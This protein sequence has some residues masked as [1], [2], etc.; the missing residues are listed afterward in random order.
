M[1]ETQ[2]LKQIREGVTGKA[3]LLFDPVVA[4]LVDGTHYTIDELAD[5]SPD[6]F[7]MRDSYLYKPTTEEFRRITNFNF[8]TNNQVT[9]ARAFTANATI[10]PAQIYFLLDVP[11]LNRCINEALPSL[12]AIERTEIAL[13]ANDNEYALPAGVHTKTQVLNVLYRD[14]TGVTDFQESSAPAWKLIE[15]GN[16]VTLHIITNEKVPVTTNTVAVIVWRKYYSTLAN[17]AATT[18]CPRELII[19]KVEMEVYKKLFKRHG[20]QAKAVFGQDLAIAE[21]DYM[22]ARET[23]IAPAEAREYHLDE[24]VEL[25][26]V[27]PTS[28]SW[29]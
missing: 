23:I 16:A 11:E 5:L 10:N 9:I 1:A 27:L 26:H 15:T 25:P 4:T 20:A 22:E 29:R 21:K 17:D 12:Y 7:R 3:G 19:P 13:V 8:P 18:T 2:T 6:P 28:W 14:S 24:P